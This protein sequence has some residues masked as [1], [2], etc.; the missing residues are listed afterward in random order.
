MLD[1]LPFTQVQCQSTI[2]YASTQHYLSFVLLDT[3]LV[4]LEFGYINTI[5]L[6]TLVTD[7]TL[8]QWDFKHLG[9][10]EPLK[11]RP[12]GAIQICLLLLLLL[13]QMLNLMFQMGSISN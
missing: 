5:K 6:N 10:S 9:L 2:V 11:L 4:I 8:K 12:Y 1:A 3:K 13:G 7:K